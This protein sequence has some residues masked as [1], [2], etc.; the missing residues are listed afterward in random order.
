[1]IFDSPMDVGLVVIIALILFGGKKLPEIF[2]NSRK[3]DGRG[4]GGPPQHPIPVTGPI[5]TK[6]SSRSK[7][8]NDS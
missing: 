6:R 1:M 4:D 7:K 2:R 8:A 3:G 5:E